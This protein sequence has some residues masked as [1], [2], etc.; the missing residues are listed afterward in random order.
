VVWVKNSKAHRIYLTSPNG[1]V[2]KTVVKN[3]DTLP[4]DL[5]AG[6]Y[7]GF[8]MYSKKK[9]GKKFFKK[10]LD[11]TVKVRLFGSLDNI[12]FISQKIIKKS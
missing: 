3:L 10:V 8:L 7:T 2:V 5:R 4:V 12:I 1:L 9:C 6:T 11:G